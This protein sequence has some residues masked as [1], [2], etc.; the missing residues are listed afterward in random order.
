[1]NLDFFLVL[2]GHT[3]EVS[4]AFRNRGM[5]QE[6]WVLITATIVIGTIW[7]TLY[8]WENYQLRLKANADTPQGLFYDLCKTHRLSRTDIAYLLKAANAH[9]KEQPAMVFIDPSI[10]T[11]YSNEV[12]T[13][14]RYYEILSERLFQK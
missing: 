5:L 7:I 1:M 12:E 4:R 13:D 11:A 10:L 2:A 3:D 9:Y 14:A 8:L 6:N